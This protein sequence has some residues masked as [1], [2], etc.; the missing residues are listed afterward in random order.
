MITERQK[1][2]II[3]GADPTTPEQLEFI[4]SYMVRRYIRLTADD[5]GSAKDVS[6][7]MQTL[8]VLDTVR[9]R[10]AKDY[11]DD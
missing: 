6:V 2:Q 1:R 5:C 9:H 8:G 7:Y 10:I 3:E 4:L 11:L